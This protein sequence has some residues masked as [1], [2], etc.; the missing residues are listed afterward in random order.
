MDGYSYGVFLAP[1]AATAGLTLIQIKAGNSPLVI[2]SAKVFQVTSTTSEILRLSILRK[3][4]AA[5]VTSATPLLLN[6][7]NPTSLAVGG[8]SATGTSASAE[9]TDGDILEDD[10]WDVA[11]ASWSYL[12]VPEDRIWVPPSGI[13]GLKLQ[14]SPGAS[15][16]IGA[17]VKFI[18]YQ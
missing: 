9:G 15:M 5:T 3:S 7:N 13:V 6:S 16:T 4:A 8:T 12:P 17:W 1:T 14:T 11:S 18:E 2:T 10:D